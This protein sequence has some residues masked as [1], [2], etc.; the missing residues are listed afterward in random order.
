MLIE[1]ILTEFVHGLILGGNMLGSA[2][3]LDD[4]AIDRISLIK[5]FRKCEVLRESS[6]RLYTD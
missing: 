1:R 4:A 6:P 3:E 5:K 2:D